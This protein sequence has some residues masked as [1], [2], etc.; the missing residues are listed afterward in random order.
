MERTDLNLTQIGSV[1]RDVE[2]RGDVF[3][4]FFG[5]IQKVEDTILEIAL[6]VDKGDL[7]WIDTS[8]SCGCVST[9]TVVD[10]DKII[11]NSKIN[12]NV[13]GYGQGAKDITI[14]YTVDGKKK[15]QVI[16]LKYFRVA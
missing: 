16:R 2:L 3:N 1:V 7:K 15:Q 11:V 4:I 9:K 5:K 12:V 14:H 13:L 10:G 6:S 8:V